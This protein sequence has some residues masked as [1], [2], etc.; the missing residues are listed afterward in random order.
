[1]GCHRRLLAV[2]PDGSITVVSGAPDELTVAGV[3]TGAFGTLAG[4]ESTFYCVT[5][6]GMN[7][8]INGTMIE[9]G[10]LAAVDT[11]S[12][13]DK[14]TM[15]SVRVHMWGK[16]AQRLDD[17]GLFKLA[18]QPARYIIRVFLDIVAW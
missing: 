3:V 16:D 6:G 18:V 15:S 12:F 11:S 7:V 4:D 5:N 17:E 9:G 10:K 1:M 8:P 13:E 14:S 2:T